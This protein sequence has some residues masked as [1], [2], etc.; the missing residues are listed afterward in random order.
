[1]IDLNLQVIRLLKKLGELRLAF[2]NLS[3]KIKPESQQLIT[4]LVGFEEKNRSL[5]S[6]SQS[7]G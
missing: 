6:E 7:L 4:G 5:F 1:V 2:E 3:G